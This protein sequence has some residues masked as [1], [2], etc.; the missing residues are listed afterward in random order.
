[1]QNHY[2]HSWRSRDRDPSTAL[3]TSLERF[4]EH[5]RKNRMDRGLTIKQAAPLIGVNHNTVIKRE[6]KGGIPTPE[7]LERMGGVAAFG[8]T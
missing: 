7:H 4:G 6:L 1:M 5:L 8:I 3:R 2:P